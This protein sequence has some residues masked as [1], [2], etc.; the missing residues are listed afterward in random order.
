MRS[1]F[2]KPAIALLFFAVATVCSVSSLLAQGGTT[3]PLTWNL[4]NGTL[5]I[6]GEGAMPYYDHPFSELY[7]SPPWSKYSNSIKTC[8]IEPG[9]TSIGNY[10]FHSCYNL[11]LISIPNSISSIDNYAFYACSNLT[12]MTIPNTVT[13]IGIA[14]FAICEALTS[15]TLPNSITKIEPL[16]FMYCTGL[17]S[18][19]IPSGVTSIGS[20][21]FYYCLDLSNPNASTGLESVTIPASVTSIGDFAFN[22][23]PLFSITNLN[24]VPVAI[25]SNV[26]SWATPHT[27]LYVPADAVNNY[28]N[29]YV[30]KEFT[31]KSIDELGIEPQETDAIRVYPNPTTGELRI[32]NYELGITGIEVF[33]VYGRKLSSNH[34]IPTSSNHLISTSSNHLINISHLP[35]GIYFVKITTD[36]GAQ[37]QKIIK[38]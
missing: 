33:D 7:N 35:A 19:T 13:S 32:T 9:V 14:A 6:S 25:S 23:C 38:N 16:T 34:L 24:P 17:R 3:G 26:F 15:F 22:M 8:I 12:S 10:A 20:Y 1:F 4:E 31:I 5:T 29:A 21:A 18:F 11:T 28:Q 30:W 27:T 37:M 2:K 36:T